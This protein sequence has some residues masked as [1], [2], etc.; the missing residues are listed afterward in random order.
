MRL[1]LFIS[2]LFLSACQS[3]ADKAS[4][5]AMHQEHHRQAMLIEAELKACSD[6]GGIPVR[7]WTG[8]Q[9]KDCIFPPKGR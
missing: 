2:V 7:T 1:F 5:A 4:T 9:L 6:R 8:M 3:E